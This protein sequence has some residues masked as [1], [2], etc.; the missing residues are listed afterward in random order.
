MEISPG[1]DLRRRQA[2]RRPGRRDLSRRRPSSPSSGAAADHWNFTLDYNQVG[3]TYRTQTGYDPW[4]DQRNGFVWT[5]YNFY[6]DEG[7]VERISP[8]RLRQRPL[9]LRPATTSGATPRLPSRC[10]CARPRPP[11]SWA[12]G[13]ARRP[14]AASTSRTCGEWTAGSTAAPTTASAGSSTPGTARI[15][16]S[17]P[18]TAA[19]R[20]SLSGSLDL[21]PRDRLIIE[22]TLD[23]IRS[24]RRRHGRAALRADHRARAAP[25]AVHATA[26]AAPGG[27]A[28]RVENPPYLEEAQ[29]GDF[30]TYHMYFGSK[31]EVDPLHDLPGELVLGVLP[32]IDPRLAGLQRGATV[33]PR[34]CTARRGGSTS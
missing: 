26:V 12:T 11:S 27:A 3:P 24:E 19:T 29:A 15:P 23:Y 2:H 9:E 28:Q 14:G 30:P 1:R 21:K 22:P 17:S 16:R 4:N 7:L 32:G 34:A 33:R 8:Q 5:N 6:F 10:A 25:L 31:W 13:R 18:W 20:L